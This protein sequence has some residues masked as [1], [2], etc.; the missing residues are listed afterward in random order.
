M[1]T[2]YRI[3]EPRYAAV[4]WDKQGTER[5]I[6]LGQAAALGEAMLWLRMGYNIRVYRWDGKQF[7][8]YENYFPGDL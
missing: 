3:D 5:E 6:E 2:V 1:V 4:Q 8:V 7:A